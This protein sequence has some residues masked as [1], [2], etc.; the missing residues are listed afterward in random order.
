MPVEI[1]KGELDI[2]LD[3][4]QGLPS[5]SGKNTTYVMIYKKTYTD[6]ATV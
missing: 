2:K 1:M 4:Y 5:V 3:K 6:K